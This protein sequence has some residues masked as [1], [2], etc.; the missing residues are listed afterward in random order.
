MSLRMRIWPLIAA[1]FLLAGC[2]FRPLMDGG[3]VS[4]VRIYV[5]EEILNV[6]K[7][8]YHADFHHPAYQRPEILRVA[9][10][11]PE[12]GRMVSERYLRS[13]GDDERGH[14]YDGYLIVEAGTYNLMAYNFGTEATIVANEYGWWDMTAYT[15]EI[16]PTL[17]DSFKS[18]GDGK[19][20]ADGEPES[21]RYDADHLFVVNEENIE[22][23]HHTALDTLRN[24]NGEPWFKATSVVKSY[25]LQIGVTGIR[26][27]SSSSVLLT[28]MGR[29]TRLRDRNFTEGGE[30]TLYFDMLSGEEHLYGEDRSCIYGT[31]GTF[32]RL[33]DAD[34]QLTVSIE[35][36]TT[37]GTRLE[38]TIPVS[39]EF[40]KVNAIEHQ[41]LIIDHVINIPA[42]PDPP[43][44]EG[45]GLQPSVGEWGD[46]NSEFEV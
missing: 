8:F 7:G 42:P 13:Q 25:Y 19:A 28:G 12:D 45:G 35:M 36:V 6:T 16:S 26:Y 43:A 29:S 3:N 44:G 18:R 2:E 32:G 9:L 21:I 24:A 22:I 41:W 27:L 1:L 4:Y 33:P 34:N 11:D 37:Y 40:L 17:A 5:D 46:V 14:Y 20:K 39:Q 15:N 23:K 30:A 31:F 10:F 38:E